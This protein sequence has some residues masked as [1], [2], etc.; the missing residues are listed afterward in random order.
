MEI[1]KYIVAYFDAFLLLFLAGIYPL[2]IIAFKNHYPDEHILVRIEAFLRRYHKW[3]GILLIIV[4]IVHAKL[5]QEL[6]ALGLIM[7]LLCILIGLSY[8]FKKVMQCYWLVFHRWLSIAVLV[9]LMFHI[10]LG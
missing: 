3:I 1:V 10:A 9:L 2:R 6:S 5:T 8:C 4:T 7:F